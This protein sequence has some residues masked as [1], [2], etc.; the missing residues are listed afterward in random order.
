MRGFPIGLVVAASLC[1]CPAHALDVAALRAQ[2]QAGSVAAERDLGLAYRRGKVGP[3]DAGSAATWLRKA[4]DAGDAEAQYQLGVMY[5]GEYGIAADPGQ[6]IVWWTR[7]ANAGN[8]KAAASLYVHYRGRANEPGTV[9][10]AAMLWPEVAAGLVQAAR[11]GDPEA[12]V[13]I[14]SVVYARGNDVKPEGQK[15]AF[16]SVDACRAWDAKAQAIY[17]ERAQ[18]GDAEAALVAGVRLKFARVGPSD[19]ATGEALIEKAADA[20]VVGAINL[21]AKGLLPSTPGQPGDPKA[22]LTLFERAA[23]LE[24]TYAQLQLAGMYFDGDGVLKDPAQSLVWYR[25]AADGGSDRAQMMLGVIYSDHYGD[26]VVPVD[27]GQALKWYGLAA[28]QGNIV[29]LLHLTILYYEGRLVPR[30]VA[31]A[32]A[33]YRVMAEN[34]GLT[35]TSMFDLVSLRS[36]MTRIRDIDTVATPDEKARGEAIARDLR[37][38]LN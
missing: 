14:C 27:T 17:L 32:Y 24:S 7:A 6:A 31:M 12:E 16:E 29:A 35:S 3:V 18:A 22:A 8:A 38:Q 9:D 25:K 10:K 30:D 2:A 1:S 13:M 4:A 28:R 21:M 36:D 26:H 34:A 11:D 33:W 20:G 19:A 37:A 15:P 5:T 23:G